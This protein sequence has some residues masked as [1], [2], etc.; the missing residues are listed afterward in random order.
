MKGDN[1]ARRTVQERAA[2]AALM[3][4]VARGL[5]NLDETITKE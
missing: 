2:L 1:G 3:T 5:L 4:A